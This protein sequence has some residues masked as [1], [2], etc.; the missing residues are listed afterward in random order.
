LKFL[1]PNL[2]SPGAYGVMLDGAHEEI[3]S[4]TFLPKT[5]GQYGA[6]AMVSTGDGERRDER[7]LAIPDGFDPHAW[8]LV[9]LESNG[10]AVSLS[11]DGN[12]A[13]WEGEL[14]S[15]P[16]RFTCF[17]R[18]VSAGFSSFELTAGWEDQF[19]SACDNL[20]VLGWKTVKL[21]NRWQIQKGQL[22]HNDLQEQDSCIVK[23]MPLEAYEL[24][25]NVRLDKVSE[26]GG[27]YGFYP[28]RVGNS[29]RERGPLISLE[30]RQ[31]G[32]VI[33]A[34]MPGKTMIIPLPTG[35]DPGIWHQFRFR[36]SAGRIQ[37]AMED[38]ILGG[39]NCGNRPSSIGL[40]ADQ[41]S[42]AFDMVRVTAIPAVSA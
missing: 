26:N 32:W 3:F 34:G 10:N 17:T 6:T 16:A 21:E 42:V 27:S 23:D 20:K 12:A 38:Q 25:V 30:P 2:T 11:I 8:H 1:T 22:I 35:F 33:R 24:V 13:L 31:A 28:A 14:P 41:A 18:G 7:P 4:L 29:K 5:A 9:R 39:I 19:T 40:C 15:I 37:I 36:K